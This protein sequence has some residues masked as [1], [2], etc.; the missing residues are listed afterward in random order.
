MIA[1]IQGKYTLVR[2]TRVTG[3]D[4]AEAYTYKSALH[5]VVSINIQLA[6]RCDSFRWTD[7][8]ATWT[9]TGRLFVSTYFGGHWEAGQC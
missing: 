3:V 7:L 1:H 4:T 2:G 6:I 9:P 8:A 5:V